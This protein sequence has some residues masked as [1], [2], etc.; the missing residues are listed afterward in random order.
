[1]IVILIESVI[2]R[3]FKSLIFPIQNILSKVQ[4]QQTLESGYWFKH[5]NQGINSLFYLKFVKGYLFHW[6]FY[7][8]KLV[9]PLAQS[10]FPQ[11]N[12]WLNSYCLVGIVLDNIDGEKITFFITRNLISRI[13]NIKCNQVLQVIE[14]NWTAWHRKKAGWWG[15]TF[16]SGQISKTS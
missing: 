14:R 16:L 15:C 1:M 8:I 3:V 13:S 2:Q 7:L 4:L 10:I 5:M 6:I 9:S 12:Y 11:L